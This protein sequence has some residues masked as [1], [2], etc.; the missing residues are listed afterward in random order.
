[1]TAGQIVGITS[2]TNWQHFGDE[3][4]LLNAYLVREVRSR[5][6]NQQQ[7]QLDQLQ[8]LVLSEHEIIA[9][10]TGESNRA[11]VAPGNR[12]LADS[13][14]EIETRISQRH[15]D[16]NL[17]LTFPL[18]QITALFQL[19]RIEEQCMVLCLAP[20]V[21]PN[22]SK[23][24][25]FLQDD[26]TKKQP[27]IDLALRLF[28][29]DR[30]DQI[31]NRSLFSPASSLMKNRLLQLSEPAVRHQSFSQV[32][33]KLDDR[34]AAFL[35]QTP[36][37]DE[38][39]VDWVDV[40]NPKAEVFTTTTHNEVR[41]QT[42]RLVERCF[43][44]GKTPQ[45]PLIHLY[46]KRGSGRR[47]LA[48]LASQSIGL[49]LLVADVSRIPPGID[50]V[51]A[52]WR[53]GRESLLLPAV[54]LVEGFDNLLSEGKRGELTAFLHAS[55]DFSPLTFLSGTQRWTSDKPRQLF[56]S[57]ECPLP[58]A[59]ARMQH[60]REHLRVAGFEAGT[61]DLVE[62]AGKFNFTEG[63][64]QQT[65]EAARCIAYWENPSAPELT[66]TL[67]S[68]AG[69]SVATPS[70]GDLARKIEPCDVWSDIVLPEAQ[71]LQLRE[72]VA[73]V[74]KAQ[75]VFEL[76]GFARTFS[77]GRGLTALFEG[78]SGTGKTMA[79]GILSGALGLDL[80]KI[81]LSAVV[82][83]Y[84]GETEKNLNRVFA[85]AQ[86]SNAILF[87]DEA[88]ALFGKRS[89]V[90][91]AHDRYANLEIAFLLQRMEEYSG[92]VILASNMKQNMD[93]AF[94]RRLRFIVNFP[95]PTD[96]DRERIWQK[97][98]P[99]DAPLGSDVDF[100]WLARKLRITGGNIKNISLRAA[101]L[102]IDRHGVID[103]DCL[104]EATKREIEKI[105]KI[106]AAGEF[107][108]PIPSAEVFEVAE[109]A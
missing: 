98:F 76:W 75:V 48:A 36:Q 74:K 99:A 42:L 18:N 1:M 86:D 19:E 2:N 20:E 62:L 100:G 89:E 68:R 16:V 77:Y 41:D 104:V 61:D 9:F 88:D 84:I 25:A 21:D 103:M 85:E 32:T 83:K 34:I 53:L 50:G 52:L 78:P 82:S 14:P 58:T 12:S 31:K 37:L 64:I 93:E 17:R 69:R 6:A 35:L 30:P 63:Q 4:E 5:T 107:Q 11:P 80:Y 56:L 38:C 79:A 57:L 55:A 44:A 109:V 106:F 26:V 101:F 87:F 95:F 40:V 39:L 66:T 96:E 105:G 71:L 46:G 27:S 13:F 51:E 10:L 67:L 70:L 45:R 73:H 90:K 81:D 92:I 7:S 91:D 47:F 29:R 49:P 15:N 54:L 28:S 33:L 22:Y 72:I 102:A 94:V 8:G 23:V 3:F 108:A 43:A 97:S 59:T 65:V 24:F 60:W